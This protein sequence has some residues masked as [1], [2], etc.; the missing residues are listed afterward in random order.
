MLGQVEEFKEVR[1][2]YMLQRKLEGA[3]SRQV[4]TEVKQVE[5]DIK[6]KIVFDIRTKLKAEGATP[7]EIEQV[8]QNKQMSRLLDSSKAAMTQQQLLGI[9]IRSIGGRKVGDSYHEKQ[10]DSL[11]Q[12]S[13]EMFVH[14]ACY[15]DDFATENPRIA[16]FALTAEGIAIGGSSRVVWHYVAEKSGI[17]E[18]IER[19][20]EA[21]REWSVNQFIEKFQMDED[22][23]ELLASGIAFGAQVV[24]GIVGARSATKVFKEAKKIHKN[25]N[26]FVGPTH[27]YEVINVTK[28]IS[29][30]IGESA[31]G[32]NKHG[33][34]KRAEQQVRKL[35]KETGDDFRSKVL[36]WHP[37]KKAARA[38]E[39]QLIRQVR[40]KNPNALPGN[41][42]VH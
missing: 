2:K 10:E 16:R 34:S 25:S 1:S 6:E 35:R 4:E 5:P 12:R 22:R 37:G 7:Q 29:H 36:G 31:Q 24:T 19:V 28:G 42:G 9:R 17:T 13:S 27:T 8:L 18:R 15:V 26:S 33:L 39:T 20:E 11:L 14:A 21:V 38:K 30:K 3:T 32:L 40:E 41:K 23:A